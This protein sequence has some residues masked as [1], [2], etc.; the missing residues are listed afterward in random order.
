MRSRRDP[1]KSAKFSLALVDKLR[2]FIDHRRQ[3]DGQR[4]RSWGLHYCPLR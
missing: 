4:N 2:D 1:K 3:R